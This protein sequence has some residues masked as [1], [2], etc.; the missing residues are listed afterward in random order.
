MH[1][2]GVTQLFLGGGCGCGLEKLAEPGAG[3]GKTPGGK[4]NP[5]FLQCLKDSCSLTY[6]DEGLC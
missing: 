6:V 5:E 2:A 3:I 1:L 4:F